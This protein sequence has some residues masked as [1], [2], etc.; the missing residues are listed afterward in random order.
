[1]S[2]AR[3]PLLDRVLVSLL[4]RGAEAEVVVGDIVERYIEDL[5]AGE[6]PA[7][8]RKR[9]RRQVVTSCFEWWRP[10]AV[11]ERYTGNRGRGMG[12][13]TGIGLWMRDLRMAV[14]N[15]ARRPGFTLGVALT[16]GLGIGATAT[17]YSVVDGVMLRPLAYEDPSALVAVGAILPTAEPVDAETGLYNLAP[18]SVQSYRLF[19]E[20]SRSFENMAA[21]EPARFLVGD[22]G[23]EEYVDGARVP[24][25]LFEILGGSPALGR[26]FGGDDF[27]LGDDGVALITYGY[28]QRRYGGD[29]S[30]LGQPLE[31]AG[32]G[33]RSTIV[34][35]LSRD[36]RPPEAF[37]PSDEV[38]EIYTPMPE[39]EEGIRS[40]RR[41]SLG[42]LHVLGR[43][44]P[45]SSV[46]GARAEAEDIAADLAA[47]FPDQNVT[48]DG[49]QIGIGLND[50]HAQ[51]VGT[52]GRA[53]W[54][55]LGSAGLLLLLTAMNAATLLLSRALDRKQELGV[56]MA[57]G[58]GRTRVVRLL[59]GEAG[60][61]P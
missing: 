38:P 30:V 1:M 4:L 42:T 48:P 58:A 26:M 51:T 28:W 49:H 60:I 55:F 36:F 11:G 31:P 57:L 6:A 39:S 47:E 34:G 43:L 56:R 46:E 35:I 17:I 14:R 25:E 10:G 40:I 33:A 24:P 37:F 19:R 22:L 44:N 59:M 29:P 23:S 53:L 41:W 21:F 50:L 12:M 7:R 3:L 27:R 16:L 54:V 61:L 20:R 32:S 52:T 5:A 15:L 13:G 45:A 8:A 2:D 18:M 9:L